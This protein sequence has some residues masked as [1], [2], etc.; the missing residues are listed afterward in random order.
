MSHNDL[1]LLEGIKQFSEH[2]M[3]SVQS[4]RIA[5]I[6]A[7]HILTKSCS[8]LEVASFEGNPLEGTPN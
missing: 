5:D 7:V 1:V 6:E 4:K 2:R 3:L 8:R